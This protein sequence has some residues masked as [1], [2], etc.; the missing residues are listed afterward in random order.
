[1][2]STATRID[3]YKRLDTIRM[4]ERRVTIRSNPKRHKI[5]FIIIAI[6]GLISGATAG[7]LQDKYHKEKESQ[8]RQKQ[9]EIQRQQEIIEQQNNDADQLRQELEETK[10]QLEAKQSVVLAKAKPP[11]RFY[12]AGVEQWR[13]LVAKYF[14]ANQVEYALQI[15]SCESGGNPSAVSQ[16][17]DHGLFQIHNGLANYGS[18]IYDPEYNIRLAYQSYYAPRGWSPWSCSR[19]I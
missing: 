8:I 14:P 15:M 4:S 13:S 3:F 7:Y 6:L 11:Q 2:N 10:R 18:S 16:T 17:N 19:K 9:E 12:K 1:M 5:L